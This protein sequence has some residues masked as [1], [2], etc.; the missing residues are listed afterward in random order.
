MPA[1]ATPSSLPSATYFLP[2]GAAGDLARFLPN[3]TGLSRGCSDPMGSEAGITARSWSVELNTR[4]WGRSGLRGSSSRPSLAG[5]RWARLQTPVP[6]CVT[7][8]RR[9][10]LP[11]GPCCSHVTHG[12]V[13]AGGHTVGS[14]P[15]PRGLLGT[16]PAR[17][18]VHPPAQLAWARA[19]RGRRHRA[20]GARAR[21]S[22][23]DRRPPGTGGCSPPTPHTGGDVHAGPG[24]CLPREAVTTLSLH[25]RQPSPA[26]RVRGA[27]APAAHGGPS[28]GG[29]GG[30]SPTG[31]GACRALRWQWRPGPDSG[32]QLV[33]RLGASGTQGGHGSGQRR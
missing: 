3:R 10:L 1:L 22:G 15:V 12:R 16:P 19:P 17:R 28:G 9:P 11:R 8:R 23:R 5:A 7:G 29:R 14:E 24:S 30:A 32:C 20:P 31:A 2:P 26:C 13:L 21:W 4:L 33:G 25:R 18:P 6:P 27:E